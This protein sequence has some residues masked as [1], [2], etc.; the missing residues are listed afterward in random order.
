MTCTWLIADP[1]GVHV[2]R[3][4]L[5]LPNLARH[6]R[7][8]L[9]PSESLVLRNQTFREFSNVVM[10]ASDMHEATSVRAVCVSFVR[11]PVWCC[12]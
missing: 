4:A 9:A 7:L 11:P 8:P 2:L 12:A 1:C 6:L 5:A 3:Y 10:E